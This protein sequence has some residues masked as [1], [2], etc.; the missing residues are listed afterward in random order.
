[1]EIWTHAEDLL[2][3]SAFSE[4]RLGEDLDDLPQ[5]HPH[6]FFAPLKDRPQDPIL[7]A[8]KLSQAQPTPNVREE[9]KK[10]ELTSGLGEVGSGGGEEGRPRSPVSFWRSVLES[11]R[12]ATSNTLSWDRLRPTHTHRASTTA[13]LSEQDDAVLASA[14]Y[15]L[16]PESSRT[17]HVV[18]AEELHLSL[19]MTVIGTSSGLFRWDNTSERF[20]YAAEGSRNLRVRERDEVIS[21]SIVERF[22][23]IG[24]LLRRLEEFIKALQLR[25]V[26]DGPTV[27]ALAHALSTVLIYLRESLVKTSASDD[28]G[29]FA[30][31]WSKY[32]PYEDIL[33][34]ISD[35]Y[36]RGQDVAPD[37]YPELISSPIKIISII[38]KHLALHLERRSSGTISAIFA[39]ILDAT[40]KGY[41]HEVGVSVGYGGQPRKQPTKL[42][43]EREQYFG[44]EDEDE[45]AEEDILEALEG[46]QTD[47]PD[48]FPKPLL[49]LLPT[50]QKS[51]ILLRHAQPDHPLLGQESKDKRVRWLWSEQDILAE[52][53]ETQHISVESPYSSSTPAPLVQVSTTTYKPEIAA[54][55]HVFDM[56]PGDFVTQSALQV[57]DKSTSTLES[58]IQ[59]FAA[60]LP[61]I[62]PTLPHLTALV[63]HKLLEHASALST[64]LLAIFLTSSNN[65]NL[66]LHLNLLR[67]YLLV[68]LPAFKSKLLEALFSDA[69]EYGVDA[70]PHGMSLRSARRRRSKAKA[71]TR[72]REGEGESKQPWAVGISANLL[73]REVWPPVS[74]DLSFFL[75]TVIVD[76]VNMGWEV[77]EVQHVV[78]EEAV[79]RV[80]FAIRDLPVGGGRERWM[81]P[82]CIEA[83]DF[84]YMDYKPPRPMDVLISPHILSKYHRIFAF[85][86]RLFRVEC[87]VKSLFRMTRLAAGSPLFPT[88]VNSRRMVLHF[89]FIAQSFVSTLSSYVFDTAIGGNFDPFL[90]QLSASS[91]SSSSSSSSSSPPSPTSATATPRSSTESASRFSDVF[92]LASAHSV[93]LDRI[94]TACLLRSGQKAVGELLRQALE[95]VLEFCVVMGELQRER[96]KEWEAAGMVEDVY[97]R[98]RSKMTTFVKVLK[99]LVDKGPTSAMAAW[100]FE[101]ASVTGMQQPTGGTAALAHLL[102]RLD[103]GAWWTGAM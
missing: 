85:I 17:A 44:L 83:L 76:S 35:L 102:V 66:Q 31:V 86:L 16:D 36:G 50:A 90:E 81:N 46:V 60:P 7:E 101:G 95:L 24:T 77:D 89:Q 43:Q 41:L 45:Q 65:L 84:L 39:Y 96:V 15:R 29:L 80:G 27:H 82:L 93:L 68:T 26:K 88:L 53:N 34:A 55:F 5:I 91:P 63:F 57:V 94:L 37:V 18:S 61:S 40:S 73:E 78:L 59:R 1:M 12:Q 67:S 4:L 25:T 87:A 92:E 19:Q 103:M 62:T 71:K 56:A 20:L 74:G 99:N 51:L 100:S 32:A 64:T 3:L 21:R 6:F 69:G 38:Y 28:T 13:F 14:R 49:D 52:W 8:I 9:R 75:R 97:R 72:E 30:S 79:W 10:K 22:L 98:F 70:S 48:F 47:F 2:D 23:T 54:Q 11:Q 42:H 58:F 33:H